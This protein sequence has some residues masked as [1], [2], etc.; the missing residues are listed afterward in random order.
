MKAE[1]ADEMRYFLEKISSREYQNDIDVMN[2]LA[3]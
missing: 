1:M 3:E 2:E